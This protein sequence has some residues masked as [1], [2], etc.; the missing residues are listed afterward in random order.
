MQSVGGMRGIQQRAVDVLGLD[1]RELSSD[2]LKGPASGHESEQMGYGEPQTRMHGRPYIVPTSTVIR[3]NT[4][5]LPKEL[6]PH[7]HQ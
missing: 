4:R 7:I 1:E 5:G 3:S 6:T 2:L